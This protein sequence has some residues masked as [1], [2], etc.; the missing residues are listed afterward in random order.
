MGRE[1]EGK[2]G[3]GMEELKRREEFG[4]GKLGYWRDSGSDREVE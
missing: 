3:D 4:T 1:T 2:L